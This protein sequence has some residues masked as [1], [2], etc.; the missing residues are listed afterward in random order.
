MEDK[1]SGAA[2][3]SALAPD[4]KLAAPQVEEKPPL[5]LDLAKPEPAGK[6]PAEVTE[7]EWRQKMRETGARWIGLGL[8]I[9]FGVTILIVLIWVLVIIIVSGSPEQAEKFARTLVPLLD[10]LA[11]FAAQVFSPLLAFVLGYYF[12]EKSR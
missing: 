7:R 12:G 5:E 6:P 4:D 2:E 10:A 1:P 3:A 11:K 9:A 8:V